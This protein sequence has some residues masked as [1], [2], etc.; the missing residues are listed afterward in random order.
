MVVHEAFRFFGDSVEHVALYASHQ[1]FAFHPGILH[2]EEFGMLSTWGKWIA[3]YS[4]MLSS[5]WGFLFLISRENSQ[6]L[7]SVSSCWYV[8]AWDNS[9]SAKSSLNSR[10]WEVFFA[11]HCK[12]WLSC[13]YWIHEFVFAKSVKWSMERTFHLL[14]RLDFLK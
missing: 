6:S 2:L 8:C 11:G 4:L 10:Y 12:A 14:V 3:P 9:S 13:R 7:E 1:G 5:G